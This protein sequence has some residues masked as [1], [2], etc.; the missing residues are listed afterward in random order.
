MNKFQTFPVKILSR[1]K[2]FS[3]KFFRVFIVESKTN[4]RGTAA[5]TYST[6]E[7]IISGIRNFTERFPLSMF[8][9]LGGWSR[10]NRNAISRWRSPTFFRIPDES[11]I[12]KERKRERSSEPVKGGGADSRRESIIIVLKFHMTELE[13]RSN[14]GQQLCTMDH[15]HVGA[16]VLTRRAN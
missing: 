7:F 10:H 9:L 14:R 6:Q 1:K 3:T 2:K 8:Y 4:T 5:E 13:P 11:G 15:F 16:P 12:R